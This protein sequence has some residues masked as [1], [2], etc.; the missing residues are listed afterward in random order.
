MAF[1]V[2]ISNTIIS[3]LLN[4]LRVNQMGFEQVFDNLTLELIDAL[5]KQIQNLSIVIYQRGNSV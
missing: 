1:L 5:M 2:K 3:A 4:H